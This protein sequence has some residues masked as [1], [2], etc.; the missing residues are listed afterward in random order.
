MPIAMC[1]SK[2]QIT[3]HWPFC[4]VFGFEV[5]VPVRSLA[6]DDVKEAAALRGRLKTIGPPAGYVL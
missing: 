5:N 3:L 6:Q 2:G 1:I 4:A